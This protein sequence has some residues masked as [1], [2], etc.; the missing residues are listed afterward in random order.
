MDEKDVK[1]EEEKVDEPQAQE[2]QADEDVEKE[3]DASEDIELLLDLE[4]KVSDLLE[5]MDEVRAAKSKLDQILDLVKKIYEAVSKGY[6]YPYPAGKRSEEE[7]PSEETKESASD[8]R[9]NEVLNAIKDLS[10]R[11]E[12]LEK[13]PIVRGADTKTE[14]PEKDVVKDLIE[15]EIYKKA[16]PR[17][18]LH[19]LWKLAEE[20]Q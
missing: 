19:M 10:S 2:A 11:I 7:K 9:L 1:R 17:E 8:D 18:R 5:Q 3:V 4:E 14:E 6:P 15:P 20:G 13:E 16:D 12:T